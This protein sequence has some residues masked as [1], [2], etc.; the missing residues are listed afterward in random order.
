M[1]FPPLYRALQEKTA[2][3]ILR[4][5]QPSSG[6]RVTEGPNGLYVDYVVSG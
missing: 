2:G 6:K 1:P 5:D 3:R 4:A